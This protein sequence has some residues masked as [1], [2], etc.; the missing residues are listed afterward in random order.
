MPRGLSKRSKVQVSIEVEEFGDLAIGSIS[1]EAILSDN[2]AVCRTLM[3]THKLE[4]GPKVD[5]ARVAQKS[6]VQSLLRVCGSIK[7][8]TNEE[9]ADTPVVKTATPKQLSMSQT[10]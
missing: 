2:K 7:S 4:D 5:P 1:Q 6:A 8:E 9:T 3:E 10:S